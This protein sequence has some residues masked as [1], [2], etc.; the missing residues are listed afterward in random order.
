MFVMLVV[1]ALRRHEGWVKNDD[2]TIRFVMSFLVG[3]NI[4]P[5][6]NDFDWHTNSE[7]RDATYE[8]V[9]SKTDPLMKEFIPDL[10]SEMDENAVVIVFGEAARAAV[11]GWECFGPSKM[12][13]GDDRLPHLCVVVNNRHNEKHREAITDVVAKLVGELLGKPPVRFKS[14]ADRDEILKVA[15]ANTA[16]GRKF[17]KR[18]LEM[19]Q[20][21]GGLADLYTDSASWSHGKAKHA[22]KLCASLVS[23]RDQIIVAIKSCIRDKRQWDH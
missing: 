16:E 19:A 11:D 10:F 23:K 5:I 8:S 21:P 7:K 20:S 14:K 9:T 6:D 12:I 1:K 13:Q 3:V 22:E 2:E 15:F 18:F 17:R 4:I